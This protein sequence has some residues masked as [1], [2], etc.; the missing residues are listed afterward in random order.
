MRAETIVEKEDA[1]S[2][3]KA[4]KIILLAA[5]EIDRT[6]GMS[7]VETMPKNIFGL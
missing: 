6:K 7:V 2:Y 1:K 5:I 4:F 3:L